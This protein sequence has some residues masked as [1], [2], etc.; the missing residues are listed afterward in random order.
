METAQA[1]TATV[2]QNIM[3]DK[4]QLEPKVYPMFGEHHLEYFYEG[5]TIGLTI[6]MNVLEENKDWFV[7][8]LAL[9]STR[10]RQ[11]T[12]QLGKEIALGRLTIADYCRTS[13]LVDVVGTEEDLIIFGPGKWLAHRKY[14]ER[15]ISNL[16]LTESVTSVRNA[17]KHK[18]RYYMDAFNGLK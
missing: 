9:K 5:N 7:V 8:G 6:F 16:R 4:E 13:E 2:A 3:T 14:L 10:D 15:L 12:K 17:N 1:S 11:G 18:H